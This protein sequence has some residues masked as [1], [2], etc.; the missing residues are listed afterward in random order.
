MADKQNIRVAVEAEDGSTVWI[1]REQVQ[2]WQAGQKL[3]KRGDKAALKRK[4][5]LKSELL[6]KLRDL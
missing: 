2:Y 5:Q 3:L 4:E 6:R 1:P